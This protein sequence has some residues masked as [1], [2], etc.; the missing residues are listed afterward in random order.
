M[1]TQHMNP[2]D[3]VQ[4]HKLLNIKQ[5][6]GMHF[7]TF[8]GHNDEGIDAHEKD[9]KVALKKH[10]VSEGE[11]LVLGFGEGINVPR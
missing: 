1:K 6:I 8:G 2:E 3:A 7:A 4:A 10:G 9:L 11:F 5:S